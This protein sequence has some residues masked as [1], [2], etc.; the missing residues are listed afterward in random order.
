MVFGYTELFGKKDFWTSLCLQK[1]SWVISNNHGWVFW[2]F[3]SQWFVPYIITDFWLVLDPPKLT[4]LKLN[5]IYRC[6][7]DYK[8][9]Q[10]NLKNLANLWIPLVASAF[11]STLFIGFEREREK[12]KRPSIYS[13][14]NWNYTL[15]RENACYLHKISDADIPLLC[16][17]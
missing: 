8:N 17:N 16:M 7:F 4:T 15:W 9:M 5:I 1:N 14:R 10:Y 6:F 11:F 3:P 13:L 12:L 2:P